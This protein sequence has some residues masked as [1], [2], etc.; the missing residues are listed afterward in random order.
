[1]PGLVLFGVQHPPHIQVG[2]VFT[3]ER[4]GPLCDMPSMLSRG[5]Q[6]IYTKLMAPGPTAATVSQNG[7]LPA[8]SWMLRA[9]KDVSQCRSR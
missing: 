9:G 3:K 2:A 4:G 5:P 7:T 6:Q 8:D 1:M